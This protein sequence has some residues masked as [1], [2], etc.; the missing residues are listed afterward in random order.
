M[1]DLEATALCCT[2]GAIQL[3]G[4]LSAW[5]VRLSLGS[6][7]Q[8]PCQHVFLAF[9]GLVAAATMVS[10]STGVGSWLTCG[11]SFSLM[12]LTATCDFSRSR[13]AAW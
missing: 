8:T 7:R 4:L 2:S 1:T 12:V 11:T 5:I 13:Q 6:R 3:L 9:L 10:V